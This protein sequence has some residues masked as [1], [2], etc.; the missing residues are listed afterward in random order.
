MGRVNQDGEMTEVGQGTSQKGCGQWDLFGGLNSAVPYSIDAHSCFRL[1]HS[2]E[3]K[4]RVSVVSNEGKKGCRKLSDITCVSW[5]Q[6]ALLLVTAQ[7]LGSGWLV[8]R[9]GQ[10][11]VVPWA[12][13]PGAE[14][15]WPW[16]SSV[17]KAGSASGSLEELCSTDLPCPSLALSPGTKVYAAMGNHDFHPKNQF[18]GKE[19]RIYKQTAELW[20]PWLSDA[21]LPLFR[22]GLAPVAHV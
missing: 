13:S 1:A 19:H 6:G 10:S 7:S 9:A 21:S 12:V 17:P 22:A 8:P 5:G 15:G 4:G 11:P 2:G 20:R 3:R 16:Q 18:P 14:G